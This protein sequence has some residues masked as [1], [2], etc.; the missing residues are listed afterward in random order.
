MAIRKPKLNETYFRITNQIPMTQA[1]QIQLSVQDAEANP[2]ELQL[3]VQALATELENHSAILEPIAS[4]EFTP[5]MLT[6]GEEQGSILDVKIDLDALKSFGQ[7]LY[8]RLLGTPTEVKF[9]YQDIKFEFKGRNDKDRA[10]A[11]ADFEAFVTKLQT[12]P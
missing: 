7:W 8:D 3:M 11:M 5:E 10:A 6:K 1:L 9:E 4:S 2:E 12:K